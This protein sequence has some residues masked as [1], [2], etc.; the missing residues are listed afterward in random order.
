[1]FV[2]AL[3]AGGHG[4]HLRRDS[5]PA[6]LNRCE[7]VHIIAEILKPYS[8]GDEPAAIMDRVMAAKTHRQLETQTPNQLLSLKCGGI[9]ADGLLYEANV[10]WCLKGMFLF[11]LLVLVSLSAAVG[12]TSVDAVASKPQWTNPLTLTIDQRLG[13]VSGWVTECTAN[14][15]RCGNFERGQEPPL[16]TRVIDVGL[17]SGP[18]VPRIIV[19]NGVQ[20]H[21]V[22]L[23]HCW[24]TTPVVRTTRGNLDSHLQSLPMSSLSR[25]FQD[26][27]TITRKLGFRYLWIDSLCIVQNDAK[28][29]EEEA[30]KMAMVFQNASVTISATFGVDGTAGCFS[31]FEVP[32][33]VD[34]IDPTLESAQSAIPKC[35]TVYLR[36]FPSEWA[37]IRQA[38]LNKRGWV[39]QESVLSRRNIHF[40]K[41][42]I[43]WSCLTRVRSGDGVLNCPSESSRWAHGRRQPPSIGLTLY[44]PTAPAEELY[45]AWFDII[46]DFSRRSLTKSPDKFAA[47]AGVTTAFRSKMGDETLVGIWKDDIHA[48]LIWK[49]MSP[50]KPVDPSLQS[51]PSWSWASLDAPIEAP[52]CRQHNYEYRRAHPKLELTGSSLSWSGLELTSMV[53]QGRL[54]VRGRFKVALICDLDSNVAGTNWSHFKT[55][56]RDAGSERLLIK[57]V[58]SPIVDNKVVVQPKTTPEPQAPG[59]GICTLDWKHA[60]RRERLVYIL[61]VMLEDFSWHGN[62]PDMVTTFC[63]VL[64]L[65]P[66][67]GFGDRYRRLGVGYL[68]V[69]KE[70]FD[71]IPV[72]DITLV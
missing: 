36:R 4:E 51:I 9:F 49:A 31:D 16:P 21:Y 63:H 11:L 46:E 57:S 69:D 60:T 14:H 18:Q 13:T 50:S 23:S 64:I 2:D 32:L 6:D 67:H 72:Q 37:S 56:S 30:T 17:Q 12:L 45:I 68:Y 40:A 8:M 43:Y 48:G 54:S 61:E 44:K 38:P 70:N 5:K 35:D 42:Q 55:T 15:S 27:I 41:D 58:P 66:V 62:T 10:V 28:E 20:S 53:T 19:T 39:L 65:E 59:V 22:A 3:D 7:G 52:E 25:T 26:A 24:G 1:M 29:W 34:I 47:L 33:T 71:G